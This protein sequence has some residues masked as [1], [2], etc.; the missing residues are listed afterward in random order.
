MNANRYGAPT[1]TEIQ[2]V[3]RA[4]IQAL[5]QSG[6]PS[7]L[8]GSAAC[9]I[10]GTSRSPNVSAENGSRFQSLIIFSIS[11]TSTSLFCPTLA[12]LRKIL[13]RQ[14]L[15]LLANSTFYQQ[16]ILGILSKFSGTGWDGNV[17][18][19]SIFSYQG[20]STFP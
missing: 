10:Y 1:N 2:L 14:W 13:K 16:E 5:A 9:K 17:V 18:A 15:P 7:C 8:V 19:R 12:P 20:P 4:A 6:Y 11:R 3:A